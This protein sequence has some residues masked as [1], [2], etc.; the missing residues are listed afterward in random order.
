MQFLLIIIVL[1]YVEVL[2]CQWQ[3]NLALLTSNALFTQQTGPYASQQSGTFFQLYTQ[4][5]ANFI[6]CTNPQTSYI[7]LNNN[8]PSV[9]TDQNYFLQSGYFVA[10]DLFFQ[11]TWQN[12]G[13]KFKFGSFEFQYYYQQPSVYPLTNQFCDYQDVDVKTVNF[14]ITSTN[15]EKIQFISQNFNDGQVS[16]RNLYVSSF[17]CFPSCSSCSGPGFNECTDCYFQTP[18]NGICPTCPQNQ[19]YMKNIG[20]KPICDIGSSLIKQGFCQNYPTQTFITTQF[21]S[22]LSSPEILKWSL[23]LDPL[24]VDNTLLPNIY[25]NYQYIYGIFKYNSGVYRYINELSSNYPTHLIGFK[26]TLLI[27]NEIPLGCGIQINI[28]NMYYGSISR[29]ISGIQA[30]QLG[31]YEISDFGSYPTYSSVKKYVLVTYFDI[32]KIPLLFSA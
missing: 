12:Q 9:Q 6:T 5:T 21:T 29:E 31:V 1:A 3:N 4:T 30:H 17:N 26:I 18:T 22:N 20:C 8:Y 10:F 25:V 14:T 11:G 2:Y 32:P 19:Y 27:F 15:N 23:I 24:H 28:N 13:V 16:I 7:T